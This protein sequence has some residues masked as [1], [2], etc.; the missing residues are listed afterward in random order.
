V[1]NFGAK[2]LDRLANARGPPEKELVQWDFRF[3]LWMGY[4]AVFNNYLKYE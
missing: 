1:G 2:K 4:S 3:R